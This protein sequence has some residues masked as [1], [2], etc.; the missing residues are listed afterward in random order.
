[1]WCVCLFYFSSWGNLFQ[2]RMVCLE[3]IWWV[4]SWIV[5]A[6]GFSGVLV[7]DY[8]IGQFGMIKDQ[9]LTI[10]WVVLVEVK[11][12]CLLGVV[13]EVFQLFRR[14]SVANSVIQACEA[15][16]YSYCSHFIFTLWE[17]PVW[18]KMFHPTLLCHGEFLLYYRIFTQVVT[19]FL[20]TLKQTLWQQILCVEIHRHLGFH[21]TVHICYVFLWLSKWCQTL[22]VNLIKVHS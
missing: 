16:N 21:F 8:R 22:E 13:C 15:C 17:S 3:A 20:L 2:C 1:M 18:R 12:S 10:S 19:G 14:F 9:I 6:V 11:L 5:G 4:G 7:D